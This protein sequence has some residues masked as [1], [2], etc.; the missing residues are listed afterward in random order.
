LFG[1][2]T[3]A[4]TQRQSHRIGAKMLLLAGGANWREQAL[5]GGD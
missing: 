3:P 1:T 4:Q 2:S 5:S